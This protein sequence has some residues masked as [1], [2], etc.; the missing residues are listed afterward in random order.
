MANHLTNMWS[1]MVS[2]R[3][4]Q[5][6]DLEFHVYE[7]AFQLIEHKVITHLVCLLKW[8]LPSDTLHRVAYLVVE[9]IQIYVSK[10]PDDSKKHTF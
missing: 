8:G 1:T 9:L 7:S 5:T 2:V 6:D 3:Q 10:Q 4:S